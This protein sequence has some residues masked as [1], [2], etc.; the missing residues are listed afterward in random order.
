[1]GTVLMG[2]SLD[3]GHLTLSPGVSVRNELIACWCWKKH[4]VELSLV[5]KNAYLCIISYC[6]FTHD[7]LICKSGQALFFFSLL[8]LPPDQHLQNP[9]HKLGYQQETELLPFMPFPH[10]VNV[11]PEF[12]L[13]IYRLLTLCTDV[14]V[15]LC[16]LNSS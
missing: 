2:L 8:Q 1:M 5:Q 10:P 6:P 12:A 15:C 4:T 13:Q 9:V 3:L 14:P 7:S 16:D 11:L